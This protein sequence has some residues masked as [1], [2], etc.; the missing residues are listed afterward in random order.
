MRVVC[1]IYAGTGVRTIRQWMNAKPQDK[2]I[3][4]LGKEKDEYA[5]LQ[6][7]CHKKLKT[8]QFTSSP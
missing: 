4:P 8:S 2:R 6:Y 3:A 7:T 1:R 5:A